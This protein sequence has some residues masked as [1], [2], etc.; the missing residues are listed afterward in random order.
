VLLI[1]LLAAGLADPAVTQATIAT[2]ICVPGYSSSVRPSS[3]Y[4][5]NLKA[6][7]IAEMGL[8]GSYH[9]YIED[10]VIPIELGGSPKD[11]A[12][13]RPQMPGQA[14]KKDLVE[15]RLHDAVCS[16]SMTL[17][18][19]QAKMLDWMDTYQSLFGIWP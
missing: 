8:P 5:S 10:H 16:G 11:P 9:D 19:A 1:L 3:S 4:T 13:L 7:Q 18:A 15:D 12:N 6:K 14:A 17:S 2:T